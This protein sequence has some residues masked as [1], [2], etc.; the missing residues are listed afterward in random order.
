MA[1]PARGVYA[2]HVQVDGRE[3]PACTN[4]GIAPTFERGETRIESHLLDFERDL[5]GRVIDVS[6]TW[7]IRPEKRFS[8][9]EELKEQIIRDVEEARNLTTYSA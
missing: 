4:L 7:R 8:G 6:F 9:V 5:Y 2:G 1:V 3:Y